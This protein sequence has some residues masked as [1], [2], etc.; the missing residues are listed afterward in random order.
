[1]GVVHQGC[2][3]SSPEEADAIAKLINDLLIQKLR[4]AD[5]SVTPLTISDIMVVAPYNMQVGSRINTPK[6]E[7]V[8]SQL[9]TE[10]AV[11]T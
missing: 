4:H 8:D 6:K 9:A 11:I 3:Q 7:P 5:G 1:M 10:T 2:T